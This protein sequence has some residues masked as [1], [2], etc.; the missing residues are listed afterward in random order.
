MLVEER[1]FYIDRD[2]QTTRRPDPV[3][4]EVTEEVIKPRARVDSSWDMILNKPEAIQATRDFLDHRQQVI[5][6]AEREIA[7]RNARN[8]VNN[9]YLKPATQIEQLAD[10]TS[11]INMGRNLEI[12]RFN[13]NEPN[14]GR[15]SAVGHGAHKTAHAPRDNRQYYIPE[16]RAA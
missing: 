8:E 11:E 10:M 15:V 1:V 2:D 7:I 9:K 3:R 4:A 12:V 16:V 6:A 5:E 13:F 14:H